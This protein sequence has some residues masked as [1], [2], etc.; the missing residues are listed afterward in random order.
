L[1]FLAVIEGNLLNDIH[2]VDLVQ[3]KYGIL[4]LRTV[5]IPLK[6]GL[7]QMFRQAFASM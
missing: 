5:G 6:I 7:L 1:D 3:L 4:W 2:L